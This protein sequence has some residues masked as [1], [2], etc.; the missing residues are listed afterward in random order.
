MTNNNM[1]LNTFQHEMTLSD[2]S[3]SFSNRL[4][5][6]VNVRCHMVIQNDALS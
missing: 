3:N 2:P 4:K 5:L 1:Y 6:G